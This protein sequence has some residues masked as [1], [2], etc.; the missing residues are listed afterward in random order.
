M[1]EQFDLLSDSQ[2]GV[3]IKTILVYA[4]GDEPEIADPFIAFAFAGIKATL[5]RDKQSWLETLDAR[6]RAGKAS[7]EARKNKKEQ[8]STKSTHVECVEHDSTKSTDSDSDSDS[9]IVSESVNETDNEISKALVVLAEPKTTASVDIAL[10]ASEKPDAKHGICPYP[11][12]VGLYNE[13]LGDE[14]PKCKIATDA[15]KAAIRRTWAFFDHEAEAF[16]GYYRQVKESD[17]LCGRGKNNFQATFDWLLK[18]TNLIK[19]LEG[20]YKNG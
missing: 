14:L 20:N 19:V 6:S 3:L 4:S 18:Q 1:I 12:I 5:D 13:I 10:S 15:R 11:Q 9:D 2:A 7:A 8:S 16:N 17:F